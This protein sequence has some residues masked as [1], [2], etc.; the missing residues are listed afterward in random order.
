MAGGTRAQKP[1]G[2][3]AWIA[4][5][6]ENMVDLV[7]QEMEEVEYPVRHEMEW[8]NEHM[9]EIFS[10][11]QANFTDVFKTPGKMRGKTP[12][13]ARKRNVEENRVVSVPELMLPVAT[14]TELTALSP[15]PL[16]EIFS[17]THQQGGNRV[18]PSPFLHRVVS[19]TN[20]TAASASPKPKIPANASQPQY[21][22]LSHNLN[23]FSKYNTDSG[24][25][26]MENDEDEM[27]LPDTQPESQA[28]TQPLEVEQSSAANTPVE[29]S[30]S[31]HNADDSFHSAQENVRARGETAEPTN[32]DPAPTDDRTP[33]PVEKPDSNQET[34]SA[35]TPKSKRQSRPK[36][37]A[38]TP[39]KQ[40]E[41]AA[42][43]ESEQDEAMMSSA[44]SSRDPAP[45]SQASKTP[46]AQEDVQME[47]P[48]KEDTVLDTF[49]DIGSPSDNSTPERP[50]VRK[51]SLTFASLPAREPLT[52]SIGG[53]RLSRTSHIDLP[54]LSNA[55]RPSHMGRQT[56]A[57]RITQ[58]ALEDNVEES[59][60]MDV[61]DKPSVDN[62][63]MD[64]ASQLH[65]AKSTQSLHDRISML[66]KL[67]PSRPKKSM[68]ATAGLSTAQIAYPDLPAAKPET[69]FER[70]SQKARDTPKM[71]PSS[72]DDDDWIKPLSSPQRPTLSKSK[73]TDVME[74]MFDTD[75][76]QSA[77]KTGAPAAQVNK[78]AD[79]ERPKTSH[80]LFSS[81]RPQGHQHSASAF[82]VTAEASTTPTGS[83]RLFDGPLS[84]SKM[85]LQSIMKS[86]KGLLTSSGSPSRKEP[87]S[88]EQTRTQSQARVSVE[89][90]N[91][92]EHA[93][94]PPHAPTP[95][96][97]ETRRTR[98]STEKEEQRRQREQ[99]DRQREEARHEKSREQEKQRALQTRSTQDKSSVEPEDRAGPTASKQAQS[100][101]L[102]SREPEAIHEG[103]KT[104]G[105]QSKQND[106]RPK[107]PTREIQKP[108]MQPV[109]IRV[110]S[111]LPRHMPIASSVSSSNTQEAPA[112]VPSSA[113]KGSTLK[114]KGSN[115][116]LHTAS[117]TGSFKSSVSTQTQAQR[118]AQLANEKK[119]EQEE[120][121]NRRKEEQERKRA[122]QQQQEEAR[123]Q[124]ARS[125]AET[126]E[127]ERRERSAQEDSKKAAHMQ[128]IEKRRLE[129][130]R[131]HERQGSQ[132][133]NDE[134]PMLQ[135][136]KASAQSSQRNDM[137]VSRAPSRLG[138]IQPYGRSINPPAPNP[139][140]PP[141]RVMDEDAGH[142]PAVKKPSNVLP[143]GEAKRRKTED[144]HNPMQPMRPHM[145]PPIRHSNMRKPSVY[146]QAG[147]A[148]PSSSSIFKTAQPQRSAHPMDMGK[149]AN[150]KIPF[151]DP[152]HAP[153]GPAQKPTA[154]SSAQRAPPPPKPSPKYPSGESVHL[155]EIATDSEDEDDS[156]SEMFPVPKWAQPKELEGLLRQQDGMEVDSIFGPIAPFSL[157][158]TF[159]ADKKIKKYRDRTSSAN[160]SGPDGLTQEEIRKDVADRQRM[161]LN[162]GW[163]FN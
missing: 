89:I 54:K 32:P 108:R 130:A 119:R 68:S 98:S 132:Q 117:S 20:A 3:A 118:K 1:V 141:K 87:S 116:S 101:R 134:G 79:S 23:S 156:D 105:P 84:A 77:M 38:S 42:Q 159:K 142:R 24:Y 157:E 37:K 9:T 33:R 80:S 47:D 110:G 29:I 91:T 30:I 160:W 25:H 158:E 135:H 56:G 145:A 83:P 148:H 129:N 72:A 18:S 153:P 60:A 133:A 17:S 86:A 94:Q 74:K 67:Q 46:A 70:V 139:A 143:A 120:R 140:K 151:A 90:H 147:P 69:N 5:E 27:V 93:S 48:V 66:G 125:R 51:G 22:D 55:S 123:R 103:T 2:S 14:V 16:S 121:E 107:P 45:L 10:K 100:Q 82:N 57:Q 150:G 62:A 85:R 39:K 71:E 138:S 154:P 113:S 78:S 44:R 6:K 106:R 152:N 162:G 28:S 127:R 52:K 76:D 75:R 13:T 96:R 146:G 21:P 88:P 41:P 12:R 8:L 163:S 59:N 126:A 34:P 124:E 104:A 64:K 15:Q 99:E 111:T 112:P 137:G 61:D 58:A 4:A 53:S 102:Q 36:A 73:T 49:D 7:E 35:A 50:L 65:N 155:P 149:F 19:K 161:R 136:E 31:E 122:A 95:P 81:P 97:Q 114:K 115:T 144:E 26:G 11:G 43:P 92:G 63:N 131:R 128:A 40:D 109:S